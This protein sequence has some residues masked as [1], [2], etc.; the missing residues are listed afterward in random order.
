MKKFTFTRSAIVLE[1]FEIMAET[2]DAARDELRDGPAP[3]SS[4]FTDWYNDDY[5]LDHVEENA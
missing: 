1:T 3:T 4:E 5:S 2:E